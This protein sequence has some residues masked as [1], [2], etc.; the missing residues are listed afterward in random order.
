MKK[1][2]VFLCVSSLVL[3]SSSY[4]IAGGVDNR[5]NHSGE[6]VRTLNRNAATDSLDAIVYNPAGVMTMENG[7]YGNLSIHYVVK[8]YKNTVNGETLD[9]DDPSFVPAVLALYKRDKWAGFFA[10]TIPAGGGEVTYDKGSA[11]SRTGA[12]GLIGTLNNVIYSA[13]PGPAYDSIAYERVEGESFYY[14]YTAGVAYKFDDIISFSLAGRYISADKKNRAE[15][16]VTPTELGVAYAN[17]PVR[18]AVLDYEDE[19]TGFGFILGMNIDYNNL[20]IG[21]KY[22]TET[23]LDF[24]YDV[25]EDSITGLPLTLGSQIGVVNNM[26]HSRNLPAVLAVGAAYRFTPRFKVDVNFTAYFQEDADWEGAES[27]VDDG[28]EAGIAV[29]YIVNEKMKLSAGYLYTE[30]G[31][32]ARYTIKEAPPLDANTFGAGLVYNVNDELKI[33]CGI[34]LATYK[35]DL[36]TDSLT[37]LVIGLEKEVVMIA[38]GVQYR[39]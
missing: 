15:F 11:T 34:G 8:D 10:F 20:N 3:L 24:E 26:E 13:L 12:V 14:G 5:S 27:N 32:D 39:F 25:N 22:E 16:Q 30:T 4:L 1:I 2:F 19:A 29:E 6:Y 7:E 23:S 28:W 18:T 17:A 9:Q 21:I 38:A 31:I 36:Y 37:G 35:S 33:D